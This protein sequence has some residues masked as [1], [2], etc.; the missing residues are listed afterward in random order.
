LKM[1]VEDVLSMPVPRFEEWRQ[2]FSIRNKEMKKA[3]KR[4]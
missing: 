3:A 2:F 1:P 4:G